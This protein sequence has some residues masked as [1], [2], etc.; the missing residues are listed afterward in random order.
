MRNQVVTKATGFLRVVELGH[1]GFL[2]GAGVLK[3]QQ[4]V[5]SSPVRERGGGI[6]AMGG[7]KRSLTSCVATT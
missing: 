6:A 4:V 5:P 3:I 2:R 1:T 7:P